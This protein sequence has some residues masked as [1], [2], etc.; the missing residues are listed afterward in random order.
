MDGQT[1][2][3]FDLD[4]FLPY[5]LCVAAN[6]VGREF[7]ERFRAAFS[8]SLAEWRV[9]AHLSQTGPVS[10]R[11]IHAAVD[12]DKSK[13][14]RAAARLEAAGHITK[15]ENP[16]DRRLVELT[17]TTEGR[18]LVDR[19][20]PVAQSFQDELTARLGPDTQ[21]VFDALSRLAESGDAT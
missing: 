9:L 8:I 1:V 3:S 12:M 21:V 5:R 4:G 20:I 6:H 10:V 13:I 7:A 2:E 18:A 11:E 15:Q 16:R 19:L 14:S 17:L